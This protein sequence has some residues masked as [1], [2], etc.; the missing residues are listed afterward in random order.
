MS[1]HTDRIKK[2][3][4][5]GA[6]ANSPNYHAT[7]WDTGTRFVFFSQ[8]Q[9]VSTQEHT[10][11]NFRLVE[12][13]ANHKI[14]QCDNEAECDQFR[15]NR[16]KRTGETNEVCKFDLKNRSEIKTKC[17]YAIY[18]LNTDEDFA[19][20]IQGFWDFALKFQW[21]IDPNN[22]SK[23][24]KKAKQ[25]LNLYAKA[26]PI[27]WQL[28]QFAMYYGYAELETPYNITEGD[29]VYFRRFGG[30]RKGIVIERLNSKYVVAYYT[31]TDRENMRFSTEPFSRLSVAKKV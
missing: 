2:F 25:R 11:G 4:E 26:Q 23:V 7:S 13:Q 16:I 31:R 20:E 10:A 18:K 14:T 22:F 9:D 17:G 8:F 28:K 29:V 6:F 19:P 24:L 27:A 3:Y 15:S 12:W 1:L 30:M 21:D 5:K